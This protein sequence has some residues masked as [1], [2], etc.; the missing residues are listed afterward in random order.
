M[1]YKCVVAYDGANYHGFQVQGIKNTIQNELEK[2]LAV[3]HKKPI[4]IYAAGRTDAGVHAL[5]QVFHFNSEIDMNELSMKKAINSSLP[6]DIYIQSVEHV[7]DDFHARFSAVSK[8]YEYLIDRGEYNPLLARYR[9]YYHY[10]LDV[11]AMKHVVDL[12]I[13]E[14]DFR[15]FTKNQRLKNTTRT[16]Y[17]CSLEQEGNLLR[18]RIHG[19][20]FMHHMVRIMVGMMLEVGKGKIT[21]TQFETI[22]Q[23]KNRQLA[24]KI[25]PANGLYLVRVHY[26]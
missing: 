7:S 8:E 16:I 20:G 17:T 18:F 14:H 9:T 10:P 19:N 24:P 11:E 26:Q 4:T 21:P 6:A 1:R 23:A 12:M 25:V 13:G 5:A 2:A 15:A 3:I 22:L